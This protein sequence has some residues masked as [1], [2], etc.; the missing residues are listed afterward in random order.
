ME[1]AG[2]FV[3]N[4]VEGLEAPAIQECRPP[5]EAWPSQLPVAEVVQL[6]AIL[7]R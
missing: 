3:Y 2:L 5:L 4:Q 1:V 6:L 7:V